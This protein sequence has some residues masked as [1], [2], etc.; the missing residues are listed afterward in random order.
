M[1]VSLLGGSTCYKARGE[2]CYA[3]HHYE[4][5]AS[6]H[7]RGTSVVMTGSLCLSVCPSVRKTTHE[8][9]DG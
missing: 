2:V 6:A 5:R 1:L 4:L 7:G 8:C 3:R 9:G